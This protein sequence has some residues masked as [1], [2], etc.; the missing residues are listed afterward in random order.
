MKRVIMA[1]MAVMAIA[2]SMSARN[3]H[4]EIDLGLGTTFAHDKIANLSND[5]AGFTLYGEARYAFSKVP[6]TVGVQAMRTIYWRDYHFEG[7]RGKCDV[8]FLS[9]NVMLTCDYYFKVHPKIKFF[10]GMG[11]G[12]C[13]IENGA[14][15]DVRPDE[16]GVTIR[17]D[18][19]TSGTA[20]FMPRAGVVFFD[21]LRLSIDYRF[22][23]KANRGAYFT[24]GY[25][26]RF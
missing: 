7:G 2:T 17:E 12:M 4:I 13:R 14:G 10:T 24:A 21:R 8:D 16:F 26:I 18:D 1:I 22:Q 25:V 5:N 23:E 20:S 11:V 6:L 3:K 19:S 9:T 15:V